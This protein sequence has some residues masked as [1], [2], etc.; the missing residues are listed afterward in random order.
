MQPNVCLPP[1]EGALHL[2]RMHRVA[3]NLH[4]VAAVMKD[5]ML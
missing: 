5:G 3:S 4:S 1:N 2:G